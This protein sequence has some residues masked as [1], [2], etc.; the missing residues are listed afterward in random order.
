MEPVG[1]LAAAHHCGWV[2][3]KV[4]PAFF[5]HEGAVI[6]WIGP[7]AAPRLH[8]RAWGRVLMAEVPG[9]SN[10][11]TR[12]PALEPMVEL[13][14]EVQERSVGRIGELVA[15]GVPDRRLAVMR[16]RIEAVVAARSSGLAPGERRV[17]EDLVEALPSRLAEIE[18]CGVPDTLVHGDFHPGNVGGHA[19]SHVVLDWGD[20]F[21]GNPLIDELPSRSRSG[22]TTRM[23]PAAGSSPRGAG[24]SPPRTRGAPP[25]CSVR[26]FPS[27]PPSCTTPSAPRSNPTSAST[28]SRTS[29]RCCGGRPTSPLGPDLRRRPARVG[30]GLGGPG[31]RILPV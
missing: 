29:S 1:H 8:G 11:G 13:L 16:P 12:G 7:Q 5:A 2:W 21:V 15:L 26:C 19:D 27:S 25:T 6:D 22:V 18:S 20:S 14:T 4:V 31:G 17:V 30:H 9:P 23:P 24:S 28:T 10:H 3:L